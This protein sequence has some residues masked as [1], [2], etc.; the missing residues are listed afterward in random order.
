MRSENSL[1]E[2]DLVPFGA[3]QE[4][5]VDPSVRATANTASSGTPK[6]SGRALRPLWYSL[7]VLVIVVAI[8]AYLIGMTLWSR[9]SLGQWKA[10]RYDVAE[11][12]YNGQIAW[13][14][15][16][17]EQW[18]AHYNL[19]TT[20]LREERIEDGI[21]ELRT[22]FD[23]VP[24][25]TEVQ[26]GRLEAFSYECQ[27]RVNLAIGIEIQGDAL[28]AAGSF[29]D[30]AATYQEAE[31]LISP[32]QSVS[33]SGQSG[34]QGQSGG[35]GQPGDNQQSGND[36][37]LGGES[38]N[39]ADKNKSRVE[40]KKQKA[41][42]QSEGEDG[43]DGEDKSE[44]DQAG[45]ESEANPSPS[46]SPTEDPYEGESAEQKQRREGLQQQN[47]KRSKDRRDAQ[48]ERRSGNPNGA[49]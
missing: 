7:P 24:K 5:P 8:S 41:E 28:A 1:P 30:A 43:S 6:R 44:Q 32:C 49:W 18:V 35:Q 10:Q 4:N 27:V 36:Q 26:P 11:A 23:L 42:E 17:V 38:D 40:D 29:S 13:T 45:Q 21:S 31:D 9:S 39:P 48:D 19:G 37:Q 20:L 33:S 22:A 34:D 16:G 47:G 3:P 46:P 15:F 2:E 14:D 12:G 25:A